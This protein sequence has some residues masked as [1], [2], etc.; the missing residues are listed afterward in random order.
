MGVGPD[1]LSELVCRD[2]G[3]RFHEKI[4]PFKLF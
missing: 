4:S 3:T 2:V 1:K